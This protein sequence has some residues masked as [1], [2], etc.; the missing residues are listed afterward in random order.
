MHLRSFDLCS[1][2]PTIHRYEPEIE[3]CNNCTR[4]ASLHTTGA[5]YNLVISRFSRI[6]MCVHLSITHMNLRSNYHRYYFLW[7]RIIFLLY[8]EFKGTITT[9]NRLSIINNC[10]DSLITIYIYTAVF[11]SFK[12]NKSLHN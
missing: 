9:R 3:N 12:N 2:L 7:F 5:L 8:S 11:I 6:L 4:E 1:G 10:F